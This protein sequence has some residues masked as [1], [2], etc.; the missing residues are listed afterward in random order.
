MFD[1]LNEIVKSFDFLRFI[2]LKVYLPVNVII[3]ATRYPL[4]ILFVLCHLCAAS[5]DILSVQKMALLSSRK[6]SSTLSQCC[7]INNHFGT[8][9]LL[10]FFFLLGR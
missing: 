2:D 6:F 9:Y 7:F 5:V 1:C 3:R 8:F 4:C 10:L